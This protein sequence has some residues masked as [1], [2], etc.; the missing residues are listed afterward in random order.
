MAY[1][2]ITNHNANEALVTPWIIV[3]LIELANRL[4][5][6]MTEYNPDDIC[7]NERI[8]NKQRKVVSALISRLLLSTAQTDP[9]H[10]QI[11]VN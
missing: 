1:I 6:I 9:L 7:F 2:N 5:V 3:S 4:S 11:K 10:M 8:C